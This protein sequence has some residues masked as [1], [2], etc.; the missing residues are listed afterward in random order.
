MWQLKTRP[1]SEKQQKTLD[2]INQYVRE[3]L[4][5][6]RVIR[7]FAREDFQEN[8]FEEKNAI[9]ADNSNRL[10]KLTGLTEPLFVQIIIA[11]IVAIVWFCFG[12]SQARKFADLGIWWP[13]SSIVSTPSCPSYSCQTSLPCIHVRLCLVSV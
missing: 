3:N 11:M 7:A 5:G 1:L 4:M 8:R 10:F 13:S 9:Y 2:K 6:L 12:S